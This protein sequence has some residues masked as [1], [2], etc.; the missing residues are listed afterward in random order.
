MCYA[1]VSW[2]GKTELRFIE[3]FAPGQEGLPVYRRKKKTVT[4]WVYK[5]EMCP[6]MFADIA[7]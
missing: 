3:G 7:R 5:N 4:Q 6:M 2:H 1:A